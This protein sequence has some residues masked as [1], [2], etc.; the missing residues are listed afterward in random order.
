MKELCHCQYE[1]EIAEKQYQ[2]L[3]DQIQTYNSTKE[4]DQYLSII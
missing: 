2:Q 4:P 3:K 1:Q